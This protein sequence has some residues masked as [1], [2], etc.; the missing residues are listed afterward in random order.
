[1]ARD[2]IKFEW[3][4]TYCS[5]WLL[6]TWRS[7]SSGS[8]RSSRSLYDSF[9]PFMLPFI[10][11]G[12][13]IPPICFAILHVSVVCNH[14]TLSILVILVQAQ[15]IQGAAIGLGIHCGRCAYDLR[16]NL[17]RFW[18]S[19]SFILHRASSLLKHVIL[20]S[21]TRLRW[22]DI[23]I[24]LELF[25]IYFCKYLIFSII[26]GVDFRMYRRFLERIY[27]EAVQVIPLS[28]LHGPADPFSKYLILFLRSFSL[29]HNLLD[30]SLKL[31]FLMLRLILRS[32]SMTFMQSF[33]RIVLCWDNDTIFLVIF[34]K[35]PYVCMLW[36]TH[37]LQ[38]LVHWSFSRI[39]M[40]IWRVD[41]EWW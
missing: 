4:W 7:K 37:H 36:W 14:S 1:M 26:F 35:D 20:I 41:F 29:A 18:A 16:K 30:I 2:F 39:Q 9:I 13:Q 25:W 6:W 23:F 34:S 40:R 10:L 33:L 31:L 21:R 27:K 32:L 15:I 24:K 5:N 11:L 28:F 8:E 3:I 17:I 12:I 19:P 38:I 22:L